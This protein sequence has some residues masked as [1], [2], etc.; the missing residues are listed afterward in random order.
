MPELPEVETV[1]RGLENSLLNQTVNHVRIHR[2]RLRKPIP[3]TLETILANARIIKITRRGKYILMNL[4][5]PYTVLFHLGMSGRIIVQPYDA[6]TY[7]KQKHEHLT[8]ITKEGQCFQYIDPRRFGIIDLFPKG[9]IHPLL[10]HMGPEPLPESEKSTA[11]ISIWQYQKDLASYLQKILKN[12]KQPIKNTLLDQ[13]VIAG[14]GNIYVCEAL[15]LARISPLRSSNHLTSQEFLSLTESIQHILHQAIQ[16]GGS[17]MRDYVHS[18]GKKGYFQMQWNVYGK[19]GEEC[20][21][22]HKE[23]RKNLI[24]KIVQAGRSSFYCAYCQQ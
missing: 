10:L 13:H 19:E 2:D 1:K 12:R 14:L 22:C 4:D 18:D 11:G 20:P 16:A 23:N 8:F 17:S 24:K 7:Q 6:T 9:Q 3:I 21:V 5:K 15:F